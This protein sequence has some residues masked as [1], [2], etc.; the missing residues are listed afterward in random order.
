V[1]DALSFYLDHQTE[2]NEY[3]QKNEVLDDLELFLSKLL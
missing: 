1:F 3:I 2:G